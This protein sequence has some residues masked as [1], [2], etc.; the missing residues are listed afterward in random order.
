MPVS[1]GI[2]QGDSLSPILFNIIMDEIIKEVKTAGRRYR[3]GKHEFKIVCYAD[4][5]VVISEDEDILQ[6]LLHRFETVAGKFNMIISKQKTQ[7]FTIA[8]E[9]R[10]CKL[11]NGNVE[12]TRADALAREG[13][14]LRYIA[15]MFRVAKSTIQDALRRLREIGSYDRTTRGNNGSRRSIYYAVDRHLTT[16]GVRERLEVTLN[17]HAYGED[18]EEGIKINGVTISNFRY[19]DDAV[20]V[21]DSMEGLQTLLDQMVEKCQEHGTK[22]NTKKTKYMIISKNPVNDG[23]FV[24]DNEPLKR[25]EKLNYLGTTINDKWDH[26]TEIKC[27]IEKRK[28]S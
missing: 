6:K 9:P 20:L 24:V 21:A 14:S 3:M 13:R 5:A 2:R 22:I 15:E 1:T 27:R 11:N 28:T 17:T 19:A 4:D 26:S 12:I 7:S 25:A 16:H 23:D 8:R 18:V 10:R